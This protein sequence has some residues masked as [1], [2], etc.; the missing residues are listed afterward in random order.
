MRLR[1]LTGWLSQR[2]LLRGSDFKNEQTNLKERTN[3]MGSWS[4]S[5]PEKKKKNNKNKVPEAGVNL[6]HLWNNKNT[7]EAR[8]T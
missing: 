6:L 7:N 4:K 1:L 8:S 2:R 5:I 3:C